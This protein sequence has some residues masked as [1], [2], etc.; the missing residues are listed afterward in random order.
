MLVASMVKQSPGAPHVAR[1]VDAI[2]EECAAAARPVWREKL[3]PRQTSVLGKACSIQQSAY[4]SSPGKWHVRL[5]LKNSRINTRT[6]IFS[7]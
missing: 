6:G 3:A 5:A 4:P 1:S 2:V 7:G